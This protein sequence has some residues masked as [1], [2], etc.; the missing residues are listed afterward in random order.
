M[1]EMEDDSSVGVDTPEDLDRVR[2]ILE[3]RLNS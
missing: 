1:V 3:A 2:A